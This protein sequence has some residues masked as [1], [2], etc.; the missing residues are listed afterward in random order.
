MVR[1]YPPGARLLARPE[2]VRACASCGDPLGRGYPGCT[3]C[4]DTVDAYWRADWDALRGD[5]DE[6]E[7]AAAVLAEVAGVYPWT[8]TD[9]ALRLVPCPACRVELAT[10]DAGCLTCSR[11]DQARWA[12]DH[13]GMPKAMT[14]NEHALRMAV[15]I[16]RAST[17]R[18]S[19]VVSFWRLVLPFLLV[20]D[21]FTTA[22][23]RRIKT[24]LLAGRYDE[25]AE[26]R[27]YAEM[28]ALPDLPWRG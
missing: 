5:D 11:A 2:V 13:G 26:A 9:W 27:G 14:A 28:T 1:P 18:R 24:L 8:C 23:A 17:R 20:G 15:A 4:A 6:R 10:G 25:L 19:T 12:W 22:Q 16:L 3:T 21:T 7:L